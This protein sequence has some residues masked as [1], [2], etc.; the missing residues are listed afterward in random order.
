LS[1]VSRGLR[2]TFLVVFWA[3]FGVLGVSFVLLGLSWSCLGVLLAFTQGSFGI[4]G[5]LEALLPCLEFI[6]G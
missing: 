6:V 2:S 3:A 4:L 5:S 1:G